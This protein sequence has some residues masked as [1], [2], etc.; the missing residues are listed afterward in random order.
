MS[1]GLDLLDYKEHCIMSYRCTFVHHSIHSLYRVSQKKRIIR[2]CVDLVYYSGY[3]RDRKLR[4]SHFKAEIHSFVLSTEQFWRYI[5]VTR[6]LGPKF[7]FKFS[8]IVV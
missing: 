1:R 3:E 2:F 5:R 6:N 8:I 4:S 7:G